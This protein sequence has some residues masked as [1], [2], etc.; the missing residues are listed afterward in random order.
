MVNKAVAV[1]SW[2]LS[3]PS[4]ERAERLSMRAAIFLGSL[5]TLVLWLGAT[6]LLVHWM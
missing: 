4:I 6:E 1:A 3:C 5:T 2:L